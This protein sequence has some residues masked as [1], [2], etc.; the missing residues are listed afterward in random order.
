MMAPQLKTE[1][2]MFPLVE[3]W[4]QSGLTQ[5]QFCLDNQLPVHILVYWVGRYRKSQPVKT[6]VDKREATANKATKKVVVTES[7]L[8]FIRLSPPAPTLLSSPAASSQLPAGNMEVVLP[9]GAIIRFSAT[10]PASY[11]KELLSLCSH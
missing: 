9:T 1:Q 4:L 10:V 2:E 11:L 7:S 3:S 8:G 5:K 6:T